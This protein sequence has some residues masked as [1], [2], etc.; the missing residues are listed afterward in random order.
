MS[1]IEELT[2]KELMDAERKAGQS[3]TSLDDPNAPKIGLM[4][5]LVW[6]IKRK[7]DKSFKYED[8]L[9]MPFTSLMETLGLED[10][11]SDPNS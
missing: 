6:V 11:D 9:D 8:A 4:T 7:D 5:A 3:I 10:D 1:K 2:A